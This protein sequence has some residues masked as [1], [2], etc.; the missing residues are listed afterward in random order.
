M[1]ELSIFYDEN[2]IQK[3]STKSIIFLLLLEGINLF[4]E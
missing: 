4:S 1:I 2:T 3:V